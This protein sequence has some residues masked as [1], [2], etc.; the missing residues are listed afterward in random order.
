[1]GNSR[2][3]LPQLRI[4]MVGAG[5]MGL[6]HGLAYATY[7]LWYWPPPAIPVPEVVA[8]ADERLALE[9]KERFGFRRATARWQDVVED[10]DV[11][12]VAVLLPNHL[13]G[14]VVHAAA[15]AGKHVICE[16]PVANSADEA[17]E[18]YDAVE[19]VEVKHQVCFNFRFVPALQLAKRL[20]DEGALG[21]LYDFRGFW[22]SDWPMDP[23]IPL[24]WRFQREFAGS[25]SLGDI[26]SHV[27]DMARMLV[28]EFAEVVGV[29]ETYV[30]ERPLSGTGGVG[31]ATRGPTGSG[32]VD[33]DDNV[34]FMIRFESGA[35]GFIE[36]TRFSPGRKNFTGFELY[37]EKGSIVFNWERLNELE[38]YSR[39]DPGDRQGFRTILTGPQ[40]PMGERFW[41]IPGYGIGYAESKVNLLADFV[42]AWASDTPIQTTF[43]D[44]WKVAEI[45]DAVL[46]SVEQGGW[47]HVV[48]ATMAHGGR[49]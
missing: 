37:G 13:H 1:M 14:E 30:R 48:G 3:E 27:I 34:A 17:R 26:G 36:A 25:G 7:P 16:K 40:H 19:A 11:E 4:G 23:Q 32:L 8:E 47:V 28:G 41:P 38:F 12:V 39:D 29:T 21:R 33:V 20:V 9:A 22:L 46:A 10:P 45:C 42:S 49:R 2:S 31:E 24:S 5:F 15:A 44:G 35:Y 18:L 43:Y 6:A